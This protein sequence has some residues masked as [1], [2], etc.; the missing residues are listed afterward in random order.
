[1]AGVLVL[2]TSVLGI[3]ARLLPKWLACAGLP[4]ALLMF[5]GFLAVV[6]FLLFLV[7]IA[8]VSIVLTLQGSPSS[9]A[10]VSPAG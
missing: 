9:T 4:E 5:V 10:A 2:A 3:R 7:W 1:V 8:V 6:P